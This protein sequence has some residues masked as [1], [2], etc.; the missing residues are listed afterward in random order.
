MG[1]LVNG[2]RKII[3]PKPEY[4]GKLLIFCEGF[5]EYNYLEYFKVYLEN[6]LRAQYSEIILEPINTEGNAMRQ[7]KLKK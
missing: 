5:T 1:R 7:K 3:S 6:N 2:E 4:A